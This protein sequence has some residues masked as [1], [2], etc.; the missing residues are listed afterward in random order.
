ME[1]KFIIPEIEILSITEQLRNSPMS[2]KLQPGETFIK[3]RNDRRNKGKIIEYLMEV[4]EKGRAKVVKRLTPYIQEGRRNAKS[5]FPANSEPVRRRKSINA[6]T[7]SREFAFSRLKG[8]EGI[9]IA[10]NKREIER[11][12]RVNSK[13]IKIVHTKK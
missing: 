4:Q 7:S 1:M 6:G 11:T 9:Y 5:T 10:E 3:K 13:T 8:T 2:K 12:E